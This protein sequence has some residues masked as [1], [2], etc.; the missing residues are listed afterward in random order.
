VENWGR[1]QMKRTS[2][3]IETATCWSC[4]TSSGGAAELRHRRID[5]LRIES[6][7]NLWEIGGEQ[8]TEYGRGTQLQQG[9]GE[10]RRSATLIRQFL[11][12]LWIKLRKNVPHS[13]FRIIADSP[14]WTQS[15][16][17]ELLLKPKR[18]KLPAKAMK[19]LFP[20]FPSTT[21]LHEKWPSCWKHSV[22]KQ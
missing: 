6:G 18:P 12:L 1:W 5:E 13:R 9:A 16:G 22:H 8:C 4:S 14:V 20:S 2:R 7:D 19:P 15:N 17:T 10:H 21:N 3:I 11:P